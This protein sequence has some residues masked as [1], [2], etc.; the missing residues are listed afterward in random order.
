MTTLN[1]DLTRF[2]QNKPNFNLRATRDKRRLKMQNEANF[3]PQN[4]EAKRMSQIRRRRS[5]GGQNEANFTPNFLQ[6]SN[7]LRRLLLKK[8]KKTRNFCKLLIL[9]HITPYTTK[10]YVN[11]SPQNTGH[12]PRET[13]DEKM[14]N[15]P[16]FNQQGPKLT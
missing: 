12:G 11:I 6:I 14:Q 2:M 4:V 1:Q 8:T 3:T 16:N 7:R 9:T 13:S 10:T 5:S 15:I